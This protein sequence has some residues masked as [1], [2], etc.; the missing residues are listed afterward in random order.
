MRNSKT[1]LAPGSS[2]A[3]SEQASAHLLPEPGGLF[4]PNNHDND[5]GKKTIAK[6]N[7]GEIFLTARL[8]A[9][10]IEGDHSR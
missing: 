1:V 7:F 5:N 2:I 3:L 10:F 9:Y 6:W 4:V 8:A